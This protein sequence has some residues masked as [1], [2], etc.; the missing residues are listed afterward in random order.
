MKKW[1]DIY[2]EVSLRTRWISIGVGFCLWLVLM[3]SIIAFIHWL[4]PIAEMDRS[5]IIAASLG[6][7]FLVVS[8]F[9]MSCRLFALL[10]LKAEGLRLARISWNCLLLLFPVANIYLYL[11]S[12]GY[13]ELAFD[14]LPIG[15]GICFSVSGK[16]APEWLFATFVY[17]AVGLVGI[18][19][20]SIYATFA[21]FKSRTG[22]VAVDHT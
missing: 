1:R 5:R 9:L 14:C 16:V 6:Q 12:V 15:T 4:F 18:T 19:A 7:V 2:N 21:Y 22:I 17:I 3:L 8:L 11:D 20:K 10:R 13:F